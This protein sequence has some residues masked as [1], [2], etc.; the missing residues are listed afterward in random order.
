[1]RYII[2]NSRFLVPVRQLV[3]HFCEL[4]SVQSRPAE[5]TKFYPFEPVP[6][7]IPCEAFQ[8]APH[9]RRTCIRQISLDINSVLRSKWQIKKTPECLQFFSANFVR[10]PKKRRT[11]SIVILCQ[12][13]FLTCN[14]TCIFCVHRRTFS[15]KSLEN[16]KPPQTPRIRHLWGFIY[17]ADDGTRTRGLLITNESFYFFRSPATSNKSRFYAVC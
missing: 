16:I 8:P 14:L 4:I 13:P 1:M 7:L 3:P 2:Q 17:E 9:C 12:S 11:V 10:F 5:K 6:I 15:S